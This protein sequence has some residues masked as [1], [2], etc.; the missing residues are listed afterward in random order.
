MDLTQRMRSAAMVIV[1]LLG[2]GWIYAAVGGFDFVHFDDDINLLLNPH[3]GSLSTDKWLWA[4][5]DTEAM[6]R[7][8]PLGWL[9][10]LG[11]FQFFGLVPAPY[12]WANVCLHAC[13]TV[14]VFIATRQ[15]MRLWLEGRGEVTGSGLRGGRGE[16]FATFAAVAWWAWHPLRVELTAWVSGLLYLQASAWSLLAWSAW[17]RGEAADRALRSASPST[18]ASLSS[19]TRW[20]VLAC[21]AYAGSL[22]AYPAG[23]AFPVAVLAWE[24]LT[25]RRALRPLCLRVLPLAALSAACLAVTLLARARASGIWGPGPS[26]AEN[27]APARLLAQTYSLFSYII[28]PVFPSELSPVYDTLYAPS[29]SDVHLWAGAGGLALVLVSAFVV[30]RRWPAV[31]VLLCGALLCLVPHLGWFESVAYPSDRYLY[32]VHAWATPALAVALAWIASPGAHDGDGRGR[33]WLALVHG[34][35]A[36]PTGAVIVLGSL[37]L[38]AWL[39]R[40]QTAVWRDSQQLFTRIVQVVRHSEVRAFYLARYA[41]VQTTLG[42]FNE[43]DLLAARA[44]AAAPGFGP[45]EAELVRS[46]PMREHAMPGLSP[47][48][49]T[50]HSLAVGHG[51][52]GDAW[53]MEAHLRRALTLSPRAVRAGYD[54]AMLLAITGRR[55][56]ARALFATLE[57]GAVSVDERARFEAS[58]RER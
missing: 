51:R 34:I 12:H 40:E 43:S 31:P 54:L 3:I 20:R 14:L 8:L 13:N 52:A 15:A 57:D 5:T 35:L 41:T 18:S 10:F 29:L 36:A 28:R 38:M 19:G 58:C 49:R 47:M 9:A 48:A 2:I 23:L 42:K 53:A 32:L 30:R 46:V 4:W 55:A 6:R 37:V 56:E 11:L 22:L 17:L 44:R 16:W 21:L 27:F 45:M 33:R 1:L 25:G 26:L 24:W 50:H 39:A 7:Y